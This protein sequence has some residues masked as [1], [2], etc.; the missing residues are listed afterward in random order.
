MG[1]NFG[2]NQHW[3]LRCCDHGPSLQSFS[4]AREKQPGPRP[5]RT[6]D[7][8]YGLPRKELT[9]HEYKELSTANF[10]AI[11]SANAFRSAVN[12]GA[13]AILENPAPRVGKPS[14]FLFQ[15]L[16]DIAGLPGVYQTEFHQCM[17]GASTAKPTRLLICKADL[18]H[19]CKSCNHPSMEW[20]WT[21]L[22]GKQRTSWAPHP[23]LVG[24]LINGRYATR[25]AAAYPYALNKALVKA[26]V[27][28]GRRW[29]GPRPS[30]TT[31]T[32]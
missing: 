12:I 23:P 2:T 7:H 13:A 21:D 29:Q 15:E 31:P 28:V 20:S 27:S 1:D 26:V 10:L 25:E 32:G 8:P 19:L 30:Q 6:V 4:A 14:I 24:R 9:E 16:V 22:E 18:R 5:L 11:M 17:L 3:P